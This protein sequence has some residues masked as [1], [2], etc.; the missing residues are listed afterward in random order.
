MKRVWNISNPAI[1]CLSSFDVKGGQNFNICSYVSVVSLKPKLYMVAIEQNSKTHSN[2][3]E[4]PFSILQILSLNNISL[5]K[6]LGKKSGWKYDKLSALKKQNILQL[7]NGKNI[8]KNSCG[9]IFL[10]KNKE[11]K[12]TGDHT[13]FIFEI[14]KST[15]I[16][17]NNIL[18]L[19][20][21]IEDKI[22]L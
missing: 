12:T 10:K 3:I 6:K 8:I 19:N 2:L 17:E 16:N 4:N 5:I 20:K 1:Y 11:I 13:L 9:I 15:T 7:W 18:T 14:L 22:I 21:L